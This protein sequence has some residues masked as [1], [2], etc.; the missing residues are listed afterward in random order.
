MES[1]RIEQ[2]MADNEEGEEM[3]TRR[4]DWEVVSLTASAYAAAPSSAE[5]QRKDDEAGRT[6][7]EAETSRALFMS[8]HF[9]FPPSQHENLP[10]EP[11]HEIREDSAGKGDF[12]ELGVEGDRS[13]RKGEKDQTV[14]IVHDEFSGMQFFDEKGNRLSV[15]NSE[16]NPD[17]EQSP[18]SAT[19]L[20]S[21]H[22]ETV[23]GGGT[24]HADP[25]PNE[26]EEA[27]ESF[28]PTAES[29][30]LSKPLNEKGYFGS[31]LP[32]SAWWKKRATSL[33]AHAKDANAFWSI[34]IAAAMMGLVLLGQQW[35]QERWQMLQQKWH[36]S[37]KDEKMGR[38]L[39]PIYR[40]KDVIV[41]GHRRGSLIRSSSSSDN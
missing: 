2:G 39:G 30:Q 40:I 18:Y 14:R 10:L 34:F 25:T 31:D 32:C 27:E 15:Q 11:E 22:S 3:N 35:Q 36:L 4:S 17:K 21:L 24:V 8:G 12:A 38:M 41:G 37:L 5:V 6:Y 20:S 33:Y 1:G 19:T 23:S 26:V 9:V 13:V 29:S 28:D 7:N 16:Y